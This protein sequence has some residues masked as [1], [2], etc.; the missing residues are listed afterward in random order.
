MVLPLGVLFS[1]S[2]VFFS[3]LQAI[4]ADLCTPKQTEYSGRSEGIAT[5]QLE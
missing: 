3:G 5:L 4:K 1:L 2:L